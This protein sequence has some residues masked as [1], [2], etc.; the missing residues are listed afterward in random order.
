M[1]NEFFSGPPRPLLVN[2]KVMKDIDKLMDVPDDITPTWKDSMGNL[3]CD[4]IQPNIFPIMVFILI[5]LYLFIRYLIKKDREQKRKKRRRRDKK[6]SK[7]HVSRQVRDINNNVSRYIQYSNKTP[8]TD[9]EMVTIN[10]KNYV[11]SNIKQKYVPVPENKPERR[12]R[13]SDQISEEYSIDDMLNNDESSDEETRENPPIH[14]QTAG[15]NPFGFGQYDGRKDLDAMA[16][17]MFGDNVSSEE[18]NGS[19]HASYQ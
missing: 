10:G 16:K 4:Y 14:P 6:R 13:D 19:D 2:N 7:G 1:D 17:H 3:Y 5:G 11:Y 15:L 12:D 18:D 9:R 8:G